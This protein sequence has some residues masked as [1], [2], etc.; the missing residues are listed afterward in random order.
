MGTRR[1]GGGIGAGSQD[2]KPSSG[3]ERL[4]PLGGNAQ[5][6]PL[7]NKRNKIGNR[8]SNSFGRADSTPPAVGKNMNT[9]AVGKKNT[10]PADNKNIP[11]ADKK[12]PP[13]ADNINPQ[14]AD[15]KRARA[16]SKPGRV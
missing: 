11:P 3:G 5:G 14:P 10:R 16:G 8:N 9:P 13:L 12:N 6:A 15:N 7:I 2:R 4:D 1:S